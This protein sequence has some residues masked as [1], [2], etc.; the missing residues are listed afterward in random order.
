LL[1]T[2]RYRV[3]GRAFAGTVIGIAHDEPLRYDIRRVPAARSKRGSADR[4]SFGV[5]QGDIEAL[6][7]PPP[8]GQKVRSC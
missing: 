2:V 7:A 3:G 1:S 5:P 4:V 8:A 6:L